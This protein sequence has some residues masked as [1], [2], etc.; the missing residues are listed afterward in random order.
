M[1]ELKLRPCPFDATPTAEGPKQNYVWTKNCDIMHSAA[2]DPLVL[3]LAL[4]IAAPEN[5][6]EDW[7][8]RVDENHEAWRR[9][10]LAAESRGYYALPC[11]EEAD[12][13]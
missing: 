3:F 9:F 7:W 10:I 1:S 13:D 5:A 12:H 4:Y 8:H 6:P 11:G 2:D